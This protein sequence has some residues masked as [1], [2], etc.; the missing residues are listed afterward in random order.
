MK[1]VV[2]DDQS[3]ITYDLDAGVPQGAVLRSIL[4]MEF[5]NDLPDDSVSRIG[6]YTD[7]NF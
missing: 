4:F 5:I 3:S 6:T 1:V 7:D 2:L